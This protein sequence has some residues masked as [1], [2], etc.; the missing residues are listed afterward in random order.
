M[1]LGELSEDELEQIKR[2]NAQER[3]KLKAKGKKSFHLENTEYTIK[4]SLKN[5]LRTFPAETGHTSPNTFTHEAFETSH[6]DELAP[7][8]SF[9]VPPGEAF[10]QPKVEK[11]EI[12]PK[13]AEDL[14]ESYR[15]FQKGIRRNNFD[16]VYHPCSANDVSPSVA[17]PKSRV[18][19]ADIDH[20]AMQ[21]LNDNGY[22]AH[23]EDAS[24]FDLKTEADVLILV[25]PAIN[26]DKAS[27]KV[28]IGGYVLCNNYFD[29]A[30]EMKQNSDFQFLGVITS[31]EGHKYFDKKNLEDYW[32]EVET[33][34]EWQKAPLTFG[35]GADY[36]T[37]AMI[38]K[39]VTGETNNILQGYKELVERARGQMR[40][41]KSASI[42]M[43]LTDVDM[44]F[45]DIV[46]L[47]HDGET[48]VLDTHLPNKKGQAD[49]I[50]VYK[51]VKKESIEKKWG[52]IKL[53]YGGIW[54]EHL[55]DGQKLPV[56]G[57]SFSTELSLKLGLDFSSFED[58][59]T[60]FTKEA[61]DSLY[62]KNKDHV[63]A[64]L[65]ETRS[66]VDP[67]SYFVCYQIQEKMKKLLEVNP[68]VPTNSFEQQQIYTAEGGNPKLSRLKGKTQCAERAALGQYLLQRAGINSTYVSGIEMQDAKNTEEFPTPH[69]F[70]VLP[71]PTKP[72]STFIFDISRP[73]SQQGVPRI[74]ETDVPFT[75]ELLKDKK[76]LL[77][78]GTEVLQGGRLWFGVGE[79]V[80][81]EHKTA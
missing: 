81:G 9:P 26:T 60:G 6:V 65:R 41:K 33:N 39:K 51:R 71:N 69:S 79:P 17:F 63:I 23:E 68:A 61:I 55:V 1:K 2:K 54:A 59:L 18:I 3:A 27:E 11:Q 5:V 45:E 20:D 19:Y 16:V 30:I 49:D 74:L 53:L 25:N 24:N 29:T 31:K 21:T 35:A 52:K 77:V 80:A 22:E 10:A 56:G 14:V 40:R 70:I 12:T 64:W 58:Q 43:E 47:E 15:C 57:T 13:I 46:L 34:E 42:S 78:G 48:F 67:Y 44:E 66:N 36:T 7:D 75:Y 32:K 8:A 37:A 72:D 62:D 4:K 50:F 76:D 73:R 38:V 28:A